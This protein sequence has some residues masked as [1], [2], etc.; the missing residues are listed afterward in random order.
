M[1]SF[2]QTLLG[3]ALAAGFMLIPMLIGLLI[4]IPTVFWILMLIDAAK[5]EFKNPNDKIVW[6][7]V[8]VFTHVLGALIYYF[9]V[10]AKDPRDE[11]HKGLSP[12]A[13]SAITIVLLLMT[14]FFALFGLVGLILM[15]FWTQW[16]KW[17]KLLVTAVYILGFLVV[18]SLGLLISK[19]PSSKS[20]TPTS[21]N[22]TIQAP[23]SL[24]QETQ[25]SEDETNQVLSGINAERIKSGLSTVVLDDNLCPYARKLALDY[26]EKGMD[27]SIIFEQ[28]LL[29]QTYLRTYFAGY[30]NMG[31]QVLRTATSD[32]SQFGTKIASSS[33]KNNQTL[34]PKLAGACV[35]GLKDSQSNWW[36]I[37]VSGV[38]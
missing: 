26:K 24:D 34:V 19:L 3:V 32:L 30:K 15:W 9:V 12:E 27:A 20:T 4:I 6:I 36:V 38:K 16:P 7:L 13:K 21:T 23:S 28:D 5:R 22:S 17:V 35:A 14:P 18:L 10:K 8:M 37:F 31:H 2:P 25:L 11:T 1:A 29:N 33:A